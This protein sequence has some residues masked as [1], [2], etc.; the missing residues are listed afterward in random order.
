MWL[1]HADSPNRR[2]SQMT[3]WFRSR[4]QL[5]GRNPQRQQIL[6]RFSLLPEPQ[7]YD[8]GGAVGRV[9]VRIHSTIILYS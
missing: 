6:M 2:F 5:G 7:K 9:I 1:M 4:R 8:A 3:G